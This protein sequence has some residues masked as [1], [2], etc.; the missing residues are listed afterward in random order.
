MVAR[1]GSRAVRGH[2]AK[3][4]SYSN[5]EEQVKKNMNMQIQYASMQSQQ[6]DMTANL[7]LIPYLL[8]HYF[9]KGADYV[10]RIKREKQKNSQG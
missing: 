4:K 9:M 10:K 8:I 1:N 7:L 5:D 6:G 3:C 2:P